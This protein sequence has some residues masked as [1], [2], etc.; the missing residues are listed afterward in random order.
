MRGWSTSVMGA[1]EGPGGSAGEQELRGD[2]LIS[3]LPERSLEPGGVGLC[4][5]GTSARSRGNGLKLRQGRLRLDVGNNFFPKGLWGIG[6]GCPG[7]C[8]SHRPWRVGQMD[9]RFSGHG[10]V[11]GVGYGWT[12]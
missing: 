1:A 8:W 5:P 6:T 12:G 10:A 4:S 2:L 11:P 3:E 7:Q 9:M